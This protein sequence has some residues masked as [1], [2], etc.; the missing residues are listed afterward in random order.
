MSR[1]WSSGGWSLGR[2]KID[3]SCAVDI[4]QTPASF[5][6]HAIPEGIDIQPG[7]IVVVHSVL[8]GVRFGERKSFRCRATVVRANWLGRAWARFGGLL[9]LTELYEVGFEPRH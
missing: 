8:D 3:V 6:A 5:H 4:E 2:R 7:D 9:A 1:G